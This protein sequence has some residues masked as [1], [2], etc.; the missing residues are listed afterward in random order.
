MRELK[1]RIW[2]FCHGENKFK[3]YYL[4]HL[5]IT[6]N[7]GAD[8]CFQAENTHYFDDSVDELNKDE[9]I[10]Q[11]TGLFDVNKKEIYDGDIVESDEILIGEIVFDDGRF[12]LKQKENG[13]NYLTSLRYADLKILGN[14]CEN[15]ELL[16]S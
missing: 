2:R 4:N 6:R 13:K 1:F 5:K 10:Q 7:G 3:F 15:P 14:I 16:L 12:N 9:V 11:F 8:I